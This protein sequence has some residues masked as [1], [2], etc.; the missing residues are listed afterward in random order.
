LHN[1]LCQGKGV[2]KGEGEG[3][4]HSNWQ[5]CISAIISG[6]ELEFAVKMQA[7]KCKLQLA[8]CNKRKQLAM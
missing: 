1:S 4:E 6:Y 7:H 8:T 3:K 2:G 5:K